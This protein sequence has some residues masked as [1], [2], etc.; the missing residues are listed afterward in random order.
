MP[1]LRDTDVEIDTK[2]DWFPFSNIAPS[3]EAESSSIFMESVIYSQVGYEK[4][5]TSGLFLC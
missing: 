5:A 4:I 2:S 1:I 3:F